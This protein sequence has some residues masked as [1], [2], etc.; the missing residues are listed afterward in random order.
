MNDDK[1]ENV[2]DRLNIGRGTLSPET[3]VLSNEEGDEI[4]LEMRLAKLL[5]LLRQNSDDLVTRGQL[6]D[7][8]WWDTIVND[9]SLTKAVSDL[10]K[11]LKLHFANPPEIITIPKRGY[12][13]VS[14][15]PVEKMLIWRTGLKYALYGFSAFIL[16]ILVIRGL[17]Y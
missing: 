9:E 12:K 10:R 16:L 4:Y 1:T 2:V 6:I 17:R 3:G 13:M 7:Q 5:L 8:I 15:G 11:V 14:S